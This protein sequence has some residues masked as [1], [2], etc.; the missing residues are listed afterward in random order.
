MEA[1]EHMLSVEQL[2]SQD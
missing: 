2:Q 1:A